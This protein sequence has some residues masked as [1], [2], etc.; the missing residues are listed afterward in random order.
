M[1]RDLGKKLNMSFDEYLNRPRYEIEA[2]HR[3]T[4]DMDKKKMK[5]NENMLKNLEKSKTINPPD[6]MME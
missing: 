5:I 6:G 3:I 1:Y 2:I 4:D